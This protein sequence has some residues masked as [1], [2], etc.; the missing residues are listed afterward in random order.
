MSRDWKIENAFA[1]SDRGTIITVDMPS[2]FSQPLPAQA[3]ILVDGDEVQKIEIKTW[4][5]LRY[6]SVEAAEAGR[7]KTDFFTADRVEL[8]GSRNWILRI[9][10]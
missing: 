8:N 10:N 5:H 6:V 2:D 1:L 4:V 7:M 9:Y 3:S